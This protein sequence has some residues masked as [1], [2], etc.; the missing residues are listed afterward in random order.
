MYFKADFG[1]QNDTLKYCNDT[2]DSEI[3]DIVLLCIVEKRL[4]V[5]MFTCTWL[6]Q[7]TAAI[8][9][10]GGSGASAPPKVLICWKFRQNP[11]ISGKNPWKCIRH[12]WKPLQIAENLAKMAANVLLF[13]KN[14]V[15]FGGEAK[16]ILMRKYSHKNWP[17]NF[18][19]KFR[20]FGQKSFST[21]NTLPAP[22]PTGAKS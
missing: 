22:T 14:G 12:W 6:L 4:E 10:V 2:P 5:S 19:G 8:S 21:P 15:F 20:R 17:N 9:G 16:T 7:Q 11:G 3:S 18:F 13:G 1:C